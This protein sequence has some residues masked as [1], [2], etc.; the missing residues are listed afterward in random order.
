MF[1][2]THNRDILG[3]N[4]KAVL[5]Y[6]TSNLVHINTYIVEDNPAKPLEK[7]YGKK[8]II[9]TN[10]IIKSFWIFMRAEI[11][12]V[13]ESISLFTG[14]FKLAIMWHGV[15]FKNTGALNRHNVTA[16]RQAEYLKNNIFFLPAGSEADR[17]KQTKSF[18]CQNVFITGYPRNDSLFKGFNKKDISRNIGLSGYRRIITYA[19]TF[20]NKPLKQ[21]FTPSFFS[22]LQKR[23]EEED[24]I[25]VLKKHPN[26]KF[27]QISED[28]NN[29]RDISDLKCDVQD[30]LKISDIL[31]SDY[32]S[33]VTDY[34][35]LK[36]PILFYLYDY[37][38]YLDY[39]RD[40]YYNLYEVLPG[41]CAHNEEE[42]MN[43]IFD[44]K[45][46][47]ED[48]YQK[49]YDSFVSYFFYH[50]DANSTK[51]VVDKILELSGRL[52]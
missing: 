26:D 40:F 16:K 1:F 10:S 51:R 13:E 48:E 9:S 20:R 11:I 23:L 24:S 5:D 25:F 12:F 22:L 27:T 17:G 34:S 29:I 30:L 49:K 7:T 2:P 15:G 21:P 39:N 35:L 4:L 52:V 45:W 47:M 31:I 14:K 41:P 33:I 50:R 18:L 8:G 36:R 32:S 6:I 37:Y 44:T 46:F 42:L 38:N 3:G 28:L 19:P 43:L